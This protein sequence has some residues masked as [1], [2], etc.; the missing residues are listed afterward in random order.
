MR[1]YFRTFE[2][3]PLGV[4]PRLWP[5]KP[6]VAKNALALIGL[7]TRLEEGFTIIHIPTGMRMGK[8]YPT[9]EDANAAF[10]D[11]TTLDWTIRNFT[12]FHWRLVKKHGGY[13]QGT[14][15]AANANLWR[16]RIKP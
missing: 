9:Y 4:G 7:K 5:V 6:Y 16:W 8:I 12:K 15:K 3:T 1:V 2:P 14:T 10:G 11:L 13:A